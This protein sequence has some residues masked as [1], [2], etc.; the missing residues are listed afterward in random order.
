MI[1]LK[2]HFRVQTG[3]GPPVTVGDI[4]VTPQFEAVIVRLASSGFIWNRPT[5]ILVEQNGHITRLPIRDITRILLLWL[6]SFSLLLSIM[7]FIKFSRRKV[8]RP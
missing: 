2:D 3:V 5:A 1:R 4:T 6:L 8:I 7:S